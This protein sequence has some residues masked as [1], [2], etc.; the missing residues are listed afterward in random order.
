MSLSETENAAPACPRSGVRDVLRPSPDAPFRKTPKPVSEYHRG[1]AVARRLPLTVFRDTTGRTKQDMRRS[2]VEIAS[3]IP[4][5]V[6]ARKAGLPLIKLATFGD[7]RSPKG[8][9]RHDANVRAVEGVEGDHDAG[10]V[11]VADARERLEVAGLAGLIYTTPSHRPDKPRWRV[12]CPLSRA[13]SPAERERLCARLNGALEGALQGESFTLSQ[14]YFYGRVEGGDAPD[15][16][17]VDGRALDLADELDTGALGRDGKP[18]QPRVVQPEPQPEVD[19]DELPHVPDW[20]KLESAL[21]HISPDDRAMWIKVGQALHEAGRGGSEYR[22]RAFE[23]WDEWSAWSGKYKPGE[24]AHLWVGFGKAKRDRVREGSIYHYA[25]AAGW[26]W[27]PPSSVP[28]NSGP[29]TFESPAECA[30]APAR[31]YR[32]KGMLADGDVTCIFGQPGAGKSVIAPHLG[33]MVARGEPAFGM[34]T[35]PG[36]VFYVAAEDAHGLRRRVAGLRQRIGEAPEFFVV[37]GVSDLLSDD[38]PH[39]EALA[40]AIS[41]QRPA[42]IFVDTL[43]MAFPGLEENDARSMGRVVTVARQLAEHGAAVVLIHHDTKDEGGTPRG[44]SLFNAA[45]DMA[46]HV[47]RDEDGI[48]RGRLTKNRNGP[49]D[50]DIAF[51]IGVETLGHDEDGDPETAPVVEELPSTALSTAPRLTHGQREALAVLRELEASGAVSEAAWRDAC[52]DGR[53]VSQSEERENRKRAFNM[54]RAKL[55]ERG[56][57]VFADGNVAPARPDFS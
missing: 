41:D 19:D 25:K 34:R 47:K 29:L 26:T 40:E 54:V 50:A 28:D 11:S 38:S 8:S 7:A 12:L 52:I 43:A 36:R 51:R 22:A 18:Y 4:S 48:V 44:H 33:Y 2:L 56:L 39:L 16:V 6:A 57:I 14:T 17:L 10:S 35:K 30:T 31:S 27:P 20:E 23:M 45:L 3:A 49:C 1:D 42:L 15:V 53:R 5:R 24:C 13:H 37:G 9:L 21:P 55:A 46:M 32:V